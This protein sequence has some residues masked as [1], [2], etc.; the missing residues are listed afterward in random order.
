[1]AR[2]KIPHYTYLE[3]KLTYSNVLFMQPTV[4]KPNISNLPIHKT[5]TSIKL[6]HMFGIFTWKINRLLITKIVAT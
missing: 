2:Q 1:M 4:Q 6:S 5:K 3:P